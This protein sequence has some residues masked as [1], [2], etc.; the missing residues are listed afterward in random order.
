MGALS[1]ASIA[2]HLQIKKEYKDQYSIISF[3]AFNLVER[4]RILGCFVKEKFQAKIGQPNV[5]LHPPLTGE[6][7]A[8]ERLL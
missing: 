2:T 7:S 5:D 3:R 8:E 4:K 1:G 6:R